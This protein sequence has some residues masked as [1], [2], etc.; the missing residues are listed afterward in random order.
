MY[1]KAQIKGIKMRMNSV[2]E[3]SLFLHSAM[4]LIILCCLFTSRILILRDVL[5]KVILATVILRYLNRMRSSKKLE[6]E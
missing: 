4:K 2:I 1:F 5:I 3:I 6:L